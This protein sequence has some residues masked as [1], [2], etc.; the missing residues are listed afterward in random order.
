MFKKDDTNA[1]W[2]AASSGWWYVP[3]L[4]FSSLVGPGALP[5]LVGS[6][7][8]SLLL[9]MPVGCYWLVLALVLLSWGALASAATL[10]VLRLVD[11]LLDR[12]P[13]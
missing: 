12:R 11:L 6:G 13:R 7:E 9:T 8:H 1:P 2:T 3:V 4:L 5:L 10:G